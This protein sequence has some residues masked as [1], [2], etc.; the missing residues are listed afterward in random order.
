MDSGLYIIAVPSGYNPFVLVGWL[1]PDPRN[2]GPFHGDEWEMLNGRVLR[3]FGAKAELGVMAENGPQEDTELLEA[4]KREAYHRLAWGRA[5]PCNPASWKEVCPR[6]DIW[7]EE[8][9]GKGDARR[10]EYYTSLNDG[11][12]SD[13]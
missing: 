8:T 9:D 6:P 13:D 12:S 7:N 3:R 2:T 10:M 5:I 11:G 4:T 1:R